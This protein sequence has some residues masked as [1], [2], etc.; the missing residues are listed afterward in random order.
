MGQKDLAPGPTG[1]SIA[2]VVSVTRKRWLQQMGGGV[3]GVRRDGRMRCSCLESRG[4]R[5][6]WYRET[7]GQAAFEATRE[8]VSS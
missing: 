1:P 7:D 2:S 6:H 4:A 3:T 8:G 5:G